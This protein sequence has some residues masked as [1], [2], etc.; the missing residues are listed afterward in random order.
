MTEGV[1][2]ASRLIKG[3]ERSTREEGTINPQGNRFREGKGNLQT[4][5]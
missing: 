4:F 1:K 5:I 2:R 3:N